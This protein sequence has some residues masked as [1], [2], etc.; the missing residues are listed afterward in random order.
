MYLPDFIFEREDIR[1]LKSKGIFTGEYPDKLNNFIYY[2]L[3][4]I[5]FKELLNIIYNNYRFDEKDI[6]DVEFDLRTVASIFTAIVNKENPLLVTNMILQYY[7]INKLN[8]R[9]L[10]SLS[11]MMG[12]EKDANNR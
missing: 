10:M 4:P 1:D 9:K 5:K 2:R 6:Q 7:H 12:E 3:S 11:R 8:A